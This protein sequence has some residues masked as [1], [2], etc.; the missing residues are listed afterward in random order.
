MRRALVYALA[1]VG[2]GKTTIPVLEKIHEA[3]NDESGRA[4]VR[5]AIA[6]LKGGE[7]RFGDAASRLFSDDRTDPARSG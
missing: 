5:S 6:K 2:D 3:E 1:Y 4:F 7:E